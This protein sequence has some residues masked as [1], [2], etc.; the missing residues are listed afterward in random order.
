MTDFFYREQIKE[1]FHFGYDNYMKYAFPK[2]EL[3]PISC[4]GV[5]S[6]GSLSVTLIDTLDTLA[7]FSNK[8][9]FSK[10]VEWICSEIKNFDKD[11]NIS[12]FE[13]NIRVLGGLLSSHMLAM[14]RELDLMDG[15]EYSGCLLNLAQDLGDR[16]FKAFE[17]SKT[18]IPFGTVNLR[19]GVPNQE[20][21][22]TSVAGAGSFSLE[23]GILSRLTGDLKYEIAAIKAME[24][25]YIR[26]SKLGLLGNHI[27]NENGSWTHRDAG[28]G[29]NVDSYYEYLLKSAILFSDKKYLDL[30][31]PLYESAIT[32]LKKGNWYVEI[33][34]ESGIMTWPIFS[35]LQGFWP[36]LQVLY[37]DIIQASKTMKSFMAVFN[38]NGFSPEGYNLASDNVQPG[39]EGYPLRPELAESLYYLYRATKDSIWRSYGL[40]ILHSISLMTRT[41]CGFARVENVQI[42]SLSDL[43][44]SFFLSETLKYLYLLFDEENFVNKKSS[45]IFTTEAHFFDISSFTH[46][47]PT[48]NQTLDSS[49]ANCIFSQY[50]NL[51]SSDGFYFENPFPPKRSFNPHL[52]FVSNE[53]NFQFD[54]NQF[55]KIE[56]LPNTKDDPKKTQEVI[57]QLLSTLKINPNNVKISYSNP[58]QKNALHPKTKED[59]RQQLNQ[60]FTDDSFIQIDDQSIQHFQ[61]D[62]DENYENE[63]YFPIEQLSED[64]LNQI[65]NN[66]QNQNQQSNGPT[67]SNREKN[68][69]NEIQNEKHQESDEQMGNQERVEQ[70]EI[71]NE[72][73]ESNEQPQIT[74]PL[75]QN[76]QNENQESN[77]QMG[78]QVDKVSFIDQDIQNSQDEQHHLTPEVDESKSMNP[79]QHEKEDEHA[80]RETQAAKS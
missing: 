5:D 24:E 36:G 17:E 46:Y 40:D 54:E 18:G 33:E 63:D 68:E 11:V 34:M 73:Q 79:I 50:L 37:G 76:E 55:I 14:D 27:N 12:V 65:K 28:I 2:D 42:M 45:Y 70:N 38:K 6:F 26:R 9:E 23:F 31:I 30:F 39:R 53:N 29:A 80:Q 8:S 61:S 32:H 20:T 69:Q 64:D 21:P 71:Q 66:L 4:S 74:P 41:K 78:N 47:Q 43:M 75:E 56:N 1:M 60:K 62:Q 58:D 13:T 10:Q 51:I 22:I 77:E 7:L 35:T 48:S 25:I 3:R 72:N 59:L 57:N 52:Q 16:L 15:K 44:D 67:T 49:S 19:Y